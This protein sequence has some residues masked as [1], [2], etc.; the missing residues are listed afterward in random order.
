MI[1][2]FKFWFYVVFTIIALWFVIQALGYD[3]RAK[4]G[5]LVVGIPTVI[6]GIMLIASQKW[7]GLI[8]PFDVNLGIGVKE[9][10]VATEKEAEEEEATH[11]LPVSLERIRFFGILGWC[12]GYLAVAFLI[13]F[14]IANFVFPAAYLIVH[15]RL[16][17][18]KAAIYGICTAGLI[19]FGI[20]FLMQGDLFEG[21][22]PISWPWGQGGETI[23]PL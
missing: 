23:P 6:M 13:G 20:Q 19:W 10:A 5:P 14:N 12:L 9:I 15:Q 4:L 17:W 18:W 8:K 11:Q 16:A 1:K 3:Y 21:I 22:I 7:P 2:S